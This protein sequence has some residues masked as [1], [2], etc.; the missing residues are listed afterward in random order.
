MSN[1][2][3][4]NISFFPELPVAKQIAIYPNLVTNGNS[5][6][7][8]LTAPFCKRLFFFIFIHYTQIQ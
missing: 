4:L 5:K 1:K 7:S 2:Q 6:Q 8:F 3:Y